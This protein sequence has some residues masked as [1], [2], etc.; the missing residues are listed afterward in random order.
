MVDLTGASSVDST[1]LDVLVNGRR[2][3]HALQGYLDLV[4]EDPQIIHLLHVTGLDKLFTIHATVDAALAA[5]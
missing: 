1:I 3:V 4:T 5:H 2:R